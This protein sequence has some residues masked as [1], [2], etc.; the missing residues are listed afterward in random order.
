M[1]MCQDNNSDIPAC[2]IC[3]QCK[4]NLIVLKEWH[5]SLLDKIK[6]FGMSRF[7]GAD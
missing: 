1:W 2:G 5:Y 4:R 7:F 6:F 3:E